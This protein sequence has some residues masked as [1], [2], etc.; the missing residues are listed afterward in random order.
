MTTSLF[1][2][3]DFVDSDFSID[4]YEEP[5]DDQIEEQTDDKKRKS[6]S[7]FPFINRNKNP[8]NKSIVGKNE[9]QNQTIDEFKVPVVVDIPCVAPIVSKRRMRSNEKTTKTS[10]AMKIKNRNKKE[11]QNIFNT[12]KKTEIH[13]SQEEMLAEA[14]ITEQINLE[15]LKEYQKLQLENVKKSK[16]VER[17]IKGPFIRYLSVSM[18]IIEEV[19]EDNQ[20]DL[21]IGDNNPK[22]KT[23]SRNFISFSDEESYESLLDLLRSSRV[24]APKG[25][26][27]PVTQLP[28]RYLDPV[29]QVPYAT[30]DA[31][32]QVRNQYF[33]HLKTYSNNQPEVEQWFDWQQNNEEKWIQW[34][35]KYCSYDNS[36]NESDIQSTLSQSLMSKV[37]SIPKVVQS[38][39]KKRKSKK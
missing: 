6:K 24:E 31:F 4:E 12:K 3:L 5:N 39:R 27:C 28:A 21:I 11:T 18:P 2:F 15:S 33:E 13:M 7:K 25:S 29:T 30:T 37:N 22:A 10:S 14:K 16:L 20:K 35:Q 23:Y 8:R 19:N 9:T 38:F 34:Q 1:K 26:V 17:S 36:C 32:N